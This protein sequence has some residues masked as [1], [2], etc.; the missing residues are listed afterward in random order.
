[1][2]VGAVAVPDSSVPTSAALVPLEAKMP[3]GPL[4]GAVNVTAT[5]ASDVVIGQPFDA[6]RATRKPV[7]NGVPSGAL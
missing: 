6:A 4:P 2:Y 3:L 5:P 7:W 1:M